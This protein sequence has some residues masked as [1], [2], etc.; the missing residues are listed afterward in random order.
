MLFRHSINL[1][2][3]VFIFLHYVNFYYEK[4]ISFNFKINYYKKFEI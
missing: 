4:I 3:T 1:E 2:I